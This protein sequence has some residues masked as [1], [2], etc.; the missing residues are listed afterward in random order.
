MLLNLPEPSAMPNT[1][2]PLRILGFGVFLGP[3]FASILMTLSV[4]VLYPPAGLLLLAFPFLVLA[5]YVMALPAAIVSSLIAC[6]INLVL[7]HPGLRVASG[8]LSGAA[9]T[10]MFMGKVLQPGGG[11]TSPLGPNALVLCGALS[12][13]ACVGLALMFE[14]GEEQNASVGDR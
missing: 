6:S 5:G 13:V 12:G 1:R 9:G 2:V 10:A 7:R 14:D 11:P 4:A 8:A 3:L